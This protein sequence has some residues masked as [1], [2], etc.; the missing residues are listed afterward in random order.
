MATYAINRDG[1]F[2]DDHLLATSQCICHCHVLSRLGVAFADC[3]DASFSAAEI[4]FPGNPMRAGMAVLR[5][6]A[7]RRAKDVV[8]GTAEPREVNKVTRCLEI[9]LRQLR[10][11]KPPCSS[12]NKDME[13]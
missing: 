2:S 9:D 7:Y 11:R 1:M 13:P 3:P 4:P 10:S 6:V 8:A 5:A 12:G